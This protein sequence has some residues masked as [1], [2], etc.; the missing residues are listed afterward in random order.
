MLKKFW[1][2]LYLLNLSFHSDL[3]FPPFPSTWNRHM[4]HKKQNNLHRVIFF[5]EVELIYNVVLI[6]AV[7]HSDSV[8]YIYILFYILFHCGLS[9]DIGYSS[10][11]STV[12]PC[13]LSILYVTVCI[14]E[15]QTPTP[16]LL[17]LPFSL[18]ATSLFSM[19]VGLFLF[20]RQVH[21]CVIF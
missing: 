20:H 17:H 16:S 10:L 5:I 18:A 7:H 15:R 1:W 21:L 12:G 4:I 11:C 8:I 9:Q 13:C 2:L 3:S 19:S 6:S 14:Y